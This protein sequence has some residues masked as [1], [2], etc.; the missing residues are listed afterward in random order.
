MIKSEALTRV[1]ECLIARNLGEAIAAMDSFLAVHP[2][3]ICLSGCMC[4]MLI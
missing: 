1:L 3:Q 4:S 2:H